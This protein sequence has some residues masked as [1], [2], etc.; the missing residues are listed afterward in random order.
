MREDP[1]EVARPKA[2]AQR[3]SVEEVLAGRPERELPHLFQFWAGNEDARPPREA[4]A[5]RAQVLDWIR[6]PDH[7]QSRVEALGRRLKGVF[8]ELMGSEQQRAGRAELASRKSLEY[9]SEYDLRAS[10]A[11]LERNALI[12]AEQEGEHYAVPRDIAEA[13]IRQRRLSERGIFD[14]LTLRGHLDRL[15]SDPE[16]ARRASPQRLREMYKMYSTDTAAVARVE[17]LPG[18][19]RE[20]VEKAIL[21]FGGILPRSMFER[22]KIDLPH[23]NGRRWAMILEQSLIGTVQELEL[24]PYGIQHNDDTLVIFTE[25]SLAWLRKVAVPGDPDRPHEE[26]GR[27]VELFTNISRFLAFLQEHDV[28]YT[29]R[30]E[31]FKTTEKKILQHLI[32]NPGR[33]L[34]REDVLQFIFRFARATG[35]VDGTGERTL[36]VTSDGRMWGSRSLQ[37]K[38]ESLLEFALGEHQEGTDDMH[39]RQLRQLFIRMLKRIEPDTWYDLMYLPFLARNQYLASLDDLGIAALAAE[40]HQAGRQGAL[41]DSQRLAWNLVRW[42][43]QRLY[44]LGVLDLGY[45]AAGHPVALRLT[46]AGARLLGLDSDDLPAAGVGN[47]VVTP[48]FEVV[49]F[50]TGDDAELVHD[51]DR[52]CVRD[53]QAGTIHFRI[54][55]ESVRRALIEGM[56]LDRML[57]VLEGNSRTPVPQNVTYSIRDWALQSGLMVL[58]EELLLRCDRPEILKRLGRDPGARQYVTRT[59]DA[60]TI[61][62]AAKMTPRRMRA[63]LR[64]LGY[65][66]ELDPLLLR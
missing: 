63:L 23:W 43:R 35:L 36:G 13:L 66:V 52:F 16:R 33:E 30:G 58:N 26:L 37:E 48:D 55:A 9:L 61:Q 57:A 44:L 53:K 65:I 62:L 60:N 41:E 54:T 12:V 38:L 22:L 5:L 51:L 18:G 11:T 7:L 49:L 1:A 45:D 2:R 15:Y 10:L 42:A 32:P 21:E 29:V 46:R 31:I 56:R 4:T 20:L 3:G 24:T 47:L 17:R 64:D 25:V 50:S 34:S 40:R 28:R 59:I 8:T 6:D 39:Q 14:A 27:G 19:I